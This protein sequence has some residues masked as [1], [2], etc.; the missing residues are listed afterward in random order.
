MKKI[1]PWIDVLD[2]VENTD[3]QA[4][5]DQIAEIAQQAQLPSTNMA[6]LYAAAYCK[7]CE[8]EGDAKAHWS[9]ME[10]EQAKLRTE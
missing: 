2:G 6:H 5:R 9:V 8:L 3:F 10:V 4:R 1:L 7:A